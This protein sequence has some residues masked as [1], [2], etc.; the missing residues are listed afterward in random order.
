MGETL[1]QGIGIVKTPRTGHLWE[2]RRKYTASYICTMAFLGISAPTGRA[3]LTGSG[4]SLS[5]PR[6]A[7]DATTTSV[8]SGQRRVLTQEGVG[9]W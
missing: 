7:M 3:A 1:P 6:L 8:G 2:S 9:N 5:Y 4:V